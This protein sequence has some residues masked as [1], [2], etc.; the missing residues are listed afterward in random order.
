MLHQVSKISRRARLAVVISILAV[1]T[2]A[3]LALSQLILLTRSAKPSQLQV[4]AQQ[5][6]PTPLDALFFNAS[7]LPVRMTA[8]TAVND[9]GASTLN[10]TF[11]NAGTTTVNSVDLVAFDFNPAGRLMNV[12]TWNLQANMDA[13]TSQSLSLNLKRRVT[14][15]RRLVIS[16]ESVR[17]DAGMWQVGF[18]ELAQAIAASITGPQGTVP[19]AKHSTEKTPESYGAAFCSDAFG[20]AFRLSKIG[21]GKALS[22]FTCDRE[23][24]FS[25][26]GFNAKSLTR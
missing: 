14:P 22:A 1:S 15:G 23:Q 5:Q 8:A 9:R 11:S 4:S 21:D 17:G 13:G 2:V 18:D 25:A 26:F 16:V 12:Q 24:R 10:Y 20:R 6:Q 3:G 19:A 7:G